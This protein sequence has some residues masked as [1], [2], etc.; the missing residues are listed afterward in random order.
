MRKYLF[1]I[2]FVLLLAHA[3]VRVLVQPQTLDPRRQS[4]RSPRPD[5]RQQS[6][7]PQRIPH[8]LLPLAPAEIRPPRTTGLPQL[9]RIQRHQT[10]ARH[11]LPPGPR[12]QRRP[13]SPR[14]KMDT[15]IQMIWGGGD[16]LFD[17]ELKPLGVFRPLD[18]DE[19]TLA[20]IFPQPALGGVNLYDREKAKSGKFAPPLW[21]GTCLSSFGIIF[22]PDLYRALGLDEVKTWSD[23]TDPRLVGNVALADPTHAGSAAATYIIIL[24]RTMAD[25]EKE[26]FDLPENRDVPH[27]KLKTTPGYKKAL[28]AGW[29]VGMHRL[30]L[31]AAN[32]RYFSDAAPQVP[33]DVAAGNAAAGMA[34]DFFGRVTP[35]HRR[36]PSTTN[37]SCPPPP[38]PSPPTPSP[39][40]TAPTARNWN[41]PTTS[42]N[43]SSAPRASGY[44]SC[45]PASPADHKAEP[46]AARPSDTASTPIAPAGSTSPTTSP[47]PVDSISAA[48]G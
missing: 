19:K 24:Q 48:N 20:E 16:T 23:L 22:N 47:P 5:H 41:W 31:I 45:K 46:F 9:R 12:Q 21:V 37:S 38:P 28:N 44:G 2:A 3:P 34:I 40:S 36:P 15:G 43:S 27:A 10:P 18:L 26:Y 42:S 30:L 33:N 14:R 32:A 8:R 7:H 4:R 6:R 29:A 13:T 25:A 35:T 17:R 1:I 39:S 11:Y